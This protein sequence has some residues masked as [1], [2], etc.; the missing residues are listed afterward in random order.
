MGVV[1]ER[2]ELA[3]SFCGMTQ[4]DLGPRTD[5]LDGCPKI[6]GMMMLI[7]SMSPGVVAVDE[8]GDEEEWKVMRYASCCGIG[9][10]ATMHGEGL[11]DYVKRCGICLPG[12]E[13]LFR[14]CIVLEKVAERC[15]IS[16]IYKKSEG[17]VW[18][19]LLQKL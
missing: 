10:L 6:R 5:V 14:V 12:R 19:C 9:L 15:I 8:L 11:Q 13:E 18:E 2:S 3:G 16:H 4:N 7:R 1:D 17:N